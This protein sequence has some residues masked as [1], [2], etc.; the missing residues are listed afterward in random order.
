MKRFIA[1]LGI[2]VFLSG[3]NPVH[4]ESPVIRADDQFKKDIISSTESMDATSVT[5]DAAS[6]KIQNLKHEK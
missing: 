2:I 1:C 4:P 6:A 5:I 3:A